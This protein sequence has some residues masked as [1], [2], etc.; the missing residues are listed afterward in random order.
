MASKNLDAA[1]KYLEEQKK[2]LDGLK[3]EKSELLGANTACFPTGTLVMMK[4]GDFRPIEQIRAGDAVLTLDVAGDVYVPRPVA[5]VFTSPNTHYYLINGDL[6][7]TSGE[8]F[9]TDKGWRYVDAIVPGDSIRSRDRWIPVETKELFKAGVTVYNLEVE[10]SHNFFVA[11]DPADPWLVH[12]TGGGGG[13]GGSSGDRN[14]R[15]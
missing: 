12:N 8:R 7:A 4:D 10:D 9:M 14:V 5:N 11:V 13:G 2:K 1:H 3:N 6:K 15:K